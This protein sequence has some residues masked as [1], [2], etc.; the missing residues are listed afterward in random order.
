VLG[1]A[2]RVVR[3]SVLENG[4]R[5]V[6][7]VANI[8][9]SPGRIDFSNAGVEAVVRERIGRRGG[10]SNATDAI[11][12]V[13]AQGRGACSGDDRGGPPRRVIAV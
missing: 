11:L 5:H 10:I 7:P 12:V 3:R 8:R 6:S 9:E 2:W 4:I 1:N 13:V